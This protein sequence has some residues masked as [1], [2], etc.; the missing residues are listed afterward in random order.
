[1]RNRLTTATA[2]AVLTVGTLGACT[3]GDDDEAATASGTSSATSSE[4]ASAGARDG[5]VEC[6][7][8]ESGRG[9]PDRQ[10]EAP[11][12]DQ[13]AEGTVEVTF[14]V[15]GGR[16]PM[17]FDRASA[18]CTVAAVTS[19]VEQGFYDDTPCHRI[20]VSD[21]PEGLA[22][23]Q[24]GDPTGTGT[25]GPGFTI[26]DEPPTGLGASSMPGAALYPRGT[27]AMA[28]TAA[29]D[30]AGS[31]FFLV[32][33]DSALPPEYAV[34]GSVDEPGLAA[35]DRIAEAGAA[36]DDPSSPDNQVPR[37]EVRISE[38]TVSG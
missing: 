4:S 33:A 27:V 2:I 6:R 17:T 23:L 9:A 20:T 12:A 15:N 32:Y 3:T 38:A 21:Q 18:P 29:P 30:S 26:E 28:K 36:S 14:T 10:V 37:D 16:I 11:A 8:Q 5:R 35:L 13:P 19:L 31:Q 34:L 25:S 24:C 22:V 7:F 1:M